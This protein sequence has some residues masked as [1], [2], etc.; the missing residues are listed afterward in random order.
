MMSL[1]SSAQSENVEFRISGTDLNF[2]VGKT[3]VSM[4]DDIPLIE[5]HYNIS[6]PGL[7]LI[8][9]LL[10]YSFSIPVL[11]LLYP[12]IYFSSKL[13]KKNSDFKNFILGIPSVLSGKYS[14]VGPRKP[15]SEHNVYLGKQGLTGLWYIQEGDK[16]EEEN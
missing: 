14:L 3:S 16:S 7:K 8:K 9:T 2:L 13:G 15:G 12:F 10:D 1:V 6:N 5:V 11:F 4:L